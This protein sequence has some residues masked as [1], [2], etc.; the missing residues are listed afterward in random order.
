MDACIPQTQANPMEASPKAIV[1]PQLKELSTDGGSEKTRVKSKKA[2]GSRA[3]KRRLAKCRRKPKACMLVIGAWFPLEPSHKVPLCKWDMNSEWRV[4]DVVRYWAIHVLR[5]P[6]E[7]VRDL[8]TGLRAVG[9]MASE[10]ELN[11][12]DKLRSV[13]LRLPLHQGRY[14]FHIQWPLRP[15]STAK[16]SSTATLRGSVQKAA[17]KLNRLN[18]SSRYSGVN[19]TGT[20]S[21]TLEAK[22][23]EGVYADTY[24]HYSQTNYRLAM[25]NPGPAP[26]EDFTIA[27]RELVVRAG[28]SLDKELFRVRLTGAPSLLANWEA[29]TERLAKSRQDSQIPFPVFIPSRG[30]AKTAHLNWEAPHAFG[31]STSAVPLGFRPVVCVVVEPQE[32][33]A[34]RSVWHNA[35][36]MVLPHSKRGPGYVRWVIQRVCTK[37]FEWCTTQGNIGLFSSWRIR[38]LPYA[39]ICDDSLT[40]F[41]RLVNIRSA[42][43]QRT[44]KAM[45]L[46]YR[47]AGEASPMFRDA[48]LAVQ[49]HN[50]TSQAAVSGFLRDDGTAVC[51]KLDWKT[52]EMSLYKVVLLNLTELRRLGVEYIP[53][54]QMYEDICLNHD[55]LR[56]GD[57]GGRTMKCQQ[58]CFRASHPRKGGCVDQR[59]LER[60]GG[61]K[62]RMDDLIR[63]EAFEKLP[64][65]RQAVIQQL[66]RWVVSKE[67]S[68][69]ES[70]PKAADQ[71]QGR[72][73]KVEQSATDPLG[74]M[75]SSE[76]SK[77]AR[78]STEP[79]SSS[80]PSKRSC[81]STELD[82]RRSSSG[83]CEPSAAGPEAPGCLVPCS[84]M[85]AR[86]EETPIKSKTDIHSS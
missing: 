18:V 43:L 54:I 5:L 48:F 55:V 32:E 57:T 30:R 4:K 41:Y 1:I 84:R 79:E 17:T 62:T 68:C 86:L 69:S 34:Y 40:M 60:E 83:R 6:A 2:S 9:T 38:Q 29:T 42:G 19:T 58:Y 13:K 16:A 26:P 56:L 21:S 15:P 61:S 39:W 76:Q 22:E 66:H 46:K 64:A 82:D 52:D 14:S 28:A 27:V 67:Q 71:K 25:C 31:P 49:K 24:G 73:K 72:S 33:E 85:V 8:P 23:K 45:R 74:K 78:A 44:G 80:Q 75:T 70:D 53:Q 59:D 65:A 81:A 35:L 37:A 36:I 10:E 50:F 12:Q 3:R 63:R 77:R 20:T 7:E 47:H 11:L 51:K